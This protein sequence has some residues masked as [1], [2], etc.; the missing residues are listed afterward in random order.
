MVVRPS[1]YELENTPNGRGL[2]MRRAYGTATLATK[3][4]YFLIATVVLVFVAML[5]LTVL[6]P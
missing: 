2:I 1:E 6:H 5:V 4:I 3:A